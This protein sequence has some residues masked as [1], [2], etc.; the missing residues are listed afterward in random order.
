M[1]DGPTQ[2]VW[3]ALFDPDWVKTH[4]FNFSAQFLWSLGMFFG[5]IGLIVSWTFFS[6]G[7]ANKHRVAASLFKK[8]G[9]TPDT[10]LEEDGI[11]KSA[12]EESGPKS[13]KANEELS[14]EDT[15]RELAQMQARTLEL[16]AS[17]ARR[18]NA[19]PHS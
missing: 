12:D 7:L 19:G 9:L 16:V 8:V 5:V 6:L 4:K 14:I 15:L 3:G 2:L 17:L 11:S 1:P 10:T 13:G 18:G